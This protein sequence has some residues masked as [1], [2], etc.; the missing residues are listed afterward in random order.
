[1]NRVFFVS[2]C[3]A[4]VALAPGHTPTADAQTSTSRPVNRGDVTGV[5]LQ[6]DG[7]LHVVR[8]TRLRWAMT[9]YEVVGLDGLRP[10]TG[11]QI[12]VATSLVDEEAKADVT[13]DFGGRVLVEIPIPEDAPDHFGATINVHARRGVSRRFEL[14]VRTSDPRNLQVWASPQVTSP[15]RLPVFGRL[16]RRSGQ[17]YGDTPVHLIVRDARGPLGAEVHLR[18][19]A[20]GV[21]SH[22]F[23]I[24]REVE[25][26]LQIAARTDADDHHRAASAATASQIAVATDPA[27]VIQVKTPRV[28]RPNG[29]VPVEVAVRRAD[30]RPVPHARVRLGG[31]PVPL[32]REEEQRDD[33]R[34]PLVQTDARGR[35]TLSWDAPQVAAGW[36]DATVTV[37]AGLAGIGRGAGRATV[38]V[39]P[40]RYA[41]RISAEGGSLVPGLGARVFA[42][43]VTIDG[44][45]A[46]AGVEVRSSGGRLGDLTGTTDA[47]GVAVLT[48]RVG[49]APEDDR[50][51]GD[52]A[53]ALDL[54]V[55]GGPASQHCLAVDPD[56]AA[57]VQ[58]EPALS[59]PGG[60]IAVEV[61]R[62][63]AARSL[64]VAVV[65]L[66][67]VPG[68]L[69][70][71]A[72]EIL[73]PRQDSLAITLPDDVVGEVIVRARPLF[74]RSMQEIRGGAAMLLSQPTPGPGLVLEG[75]DG[76]P[77][78]FGPALQGRAQETMTVLGFALP[79]EVITAFEEQLRTLATAPVSDPR[80]R[81]ASGIAAVLAERTP[82]DIGAPA[83]LRGRNAE[84][85]PEPQNPE[86]LGLLRDPWRAS[87]RFIQGRLA[88]VFRAIE[89]RVDAAVPE[90]MDEIAVEER[91]RFRF[92]RQLLASLTDGLGS[93]GATGLG[94]E[95][96]TIERLESLDRAFNYDMVARRITRRRLFKLLLAMR[97]FVQSN[98]LDLAWT[99]PG[100][101]T[102]WMERLRHQHAPGLGSVRPG[103]LVDGW[104]RPFELRAVARA[105]FSRVQPVAGYELISAGPDGR[106]GNRD[107]IFDPTAAVL[108]SNSL[109]AQAV[110]EESL[111]AR[112][113]GVELGRATV[114]MASRAFGVPGPNIVA[115]SDEGPR[116]SNPGNL[117]EQLRD[118]PYALA[119]RRPTRPASGRLA[120]VEETG[121]GEA[122]AIR[123]RV[124]SEP[125]TWRTLGLGFTTSGSVS[126]AAATSRAGAPILSDM[127][128]PSRLRVGESLRVPLHVTNVTAE[129]GS[130]QLS[131]EAEGLRVELEPSITVPA[132]ETR[133][134]SVTLTG[135]EP[136]RHRARVDLSA[137]GTRVRGI[138]RRVWV[139]RGLHPMRRRASGLVRGEWEV[140]FPL[141][142]DAQDVQA[143]VV[144]M[145]AVGLVADP[146]LNDLRRDDPAL[147]AW[148]ETLAGRS[149]D[150]EV[151]A[152]LLR[153]QDRSGLVRGSEPA[154][155]TA[156]A[157]VAWSAAL[158]DEG[159]ADVAAQAARQQAIQRLGGLPPLR[160]RDGVAG[161]IRMQSATLAALATSGV[162]DVPTGN[163]L[164]D[165]VSATLAQWL[166]LLR[167]VLIDSPA[168]PTLLARAAAALLLADPRDGHG[169]AMYAKAIEHID[170]R[171]VTPSENRPGL[172]ESI[173]ATLA[174]A[175]AAHQMGDSERA[176]DLIAGAAPHA[177][178]FTRRGGEAAFWWLACGSYGALG[179]NT[180]E[181]EVGVRGGGAA[182]PL[183][184]EGGRGATPLDLRP[185]RS[186]TIRIRS[187][188]VV[189]ARIEAV[190]GQPFAADTDGP[191]VTTIEG[192]SGGV[193]DVAAFELS[194]TARRAVNAPVVEI[195]LPAGVEADA[196]LLAALQAN[197]AVIEA[198]PRHPGFVRLRLTPLAEDATHTLPLALRW[199]VGGDVRGLGIVSYPADR[200]DA[201]T[202]LPPRE[203][204]LQ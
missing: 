100:D 171:R 203:L 51:G 137:G 142:S 44:D 66:H 173:S 108:P 178:T 162:T 147:V 64:P 139:D 127:Q 55:A 57:R 90:Q 21:F 118:D 24:P 27:L 3:L 138:E 111:V 87:H 141:P 48:G 160:D 143:R 8:G 158:N 149:V 46:P 85:T 33:R 63:A 102:L 136:G 69:E 155:S 94:G 49:D 28:A 187:E 189:F 101:A 52:A 2:L 170:D 19:D 121:A 124:G 4:L 73:P 140:E 192:E 62:V 41:A 201:M 61:E 144:A 156:S 67:R 128:I 135:T 182:G 6:L 43:V 92:N 151:A 16:A 13:T 166:P 165:P 76:S 5:E 42:R 32:T 168:E 84:P 202:V 74:G 15:G 72:S 175:I 116:S 25:G 9:A 81:S 195:Q 115:P 40:A 109:Y 89:A 36:S 161:R 126:F 58:L 200:P 176:L 54:H 104:G 157:I 11:A 117:P 188:S 70:V 98:T 91:G 7:P 153:S 78:L 35:V 10:A 129:T 131:S 18:T 133:S 17:A 197:G 132:G 196:Q 145:S 112:L 159:H 26:A 154:L 83:V 80:I 190:Y 193:G 169:R 97:Q 172:E 174:L 37:Q 181:V 20:R 65:A 99:R 199:R 167:R 184:L 198:T 146:D 179:A 185:G 148:A 82:S 86:Q 110:D 113:R 130:F 31:R 12:Q 29:A 30:G 164:R 204:H 191:L 134:L 163:P 103:E 120:H 180:G 107:D 122:A 23:R 88:L 45:P 152:R 106:Y 123:L 194:V 77:E 183:V 14:Q 125:R 38:R 50:C 119:I 105:R 53:T 34:Y 47:F 71:V 114:E 95:P 96:L 56:A 186:A 68:G 177:P 93:E 75:N 22:E 59:H 39:S 60:E 79:I 1:M 150:P